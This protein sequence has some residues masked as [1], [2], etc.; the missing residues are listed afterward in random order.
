MTAT[1]NRV[2][3]PLIIISNDYIGSNCYLQDV[4]EVAQ[5]RSRSNGPKC[6]ELRFFWWQPWLSWKCDS[7]SFHKRLLACHRSLPLSYRARTNW[8]DQ[9]SGRYLEPA[10]TTFLVAATWFWRVRSSTS[11][12]GSLGHLKSA[13]YRC[14]SGAQVDWVRYQASAAMQGKVPR[15]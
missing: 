5:T 2:V 12:W 6:K 10:N 9:I 13:F 11:W 1:S 15:W 3:R 4:V 8:F 7:P 14:R